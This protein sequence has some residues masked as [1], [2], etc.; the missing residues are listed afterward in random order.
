MTNDEISQKKSEN[1]CLLAL[2]LSFVALIPHSI[3]VRTLS[4]SIWIIESS[5]LTLNCLLPLVVTFENGLKVVALEDSGFF[6]R[7]CLGN[8]RPFKMHVVFSY[9]QVHMT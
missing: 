5:R 9:V 1:L 3:L 2:Y 6:A 4:K 8:S 7:W